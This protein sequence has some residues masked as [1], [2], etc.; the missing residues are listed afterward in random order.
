M[1]SAT[2]RATNATTSAPRPHGP[3]ASRNRV[4]TIVG[5]CGK[6]PLGSIRH[7]GGRCAGLSGLSFYRRTVTRGCAK[8]QVEFTKPQ[9]R[10]HHREDLVPAASKRG[11]CD[12]GLLEW[13]QSEAT[14]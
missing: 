9:V 3:R 10:R 8:P 2:W 6:V 11:L 5:H 14:H 4:K 12:G 7:L 13:R 1:V